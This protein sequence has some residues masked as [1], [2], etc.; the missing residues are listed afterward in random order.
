[1]ARK[2]TTPEPQAKARTSKIDI[3]IALLSRPEGADIEA[4]SQ[5]TGW[6]A[7]SVRG[8]L[9][10]ALKTKRGLAI[11]SEKTAAGRVYRIVAA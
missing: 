4:L 11:V 10:G 5:A 7:H 9:S 2:T 3:V 1:M 8:A 6:Q